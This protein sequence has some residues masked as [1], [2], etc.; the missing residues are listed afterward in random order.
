M[1]LGKNWGRWV[2]LGKTKQNQD[3]VRDLKE[4]NIGFFNDHTVRII[5]AQ[6]SDDR[7]PLEEVVQN[8]VKYRSLCS[9]PHSRL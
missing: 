4:M 8:V 5:D 6:P 7:L 3:M 2:R 1:V 9:A